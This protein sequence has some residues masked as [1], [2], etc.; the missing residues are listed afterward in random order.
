MSAAKDNITQQK[1]DQHPEPTVFL[2]SRIGANIHVPS[3]FFLFKFVRAVVSEKNLSMK[4]PRR[5]NE[6]MSNG[7]GK[8]GP[9]SE[10]VE[11]AHELG[12]A[13]TSEERWRRS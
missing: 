9:C 2:Q 12:T 6:L 10:V 4:L 5:P 1:N 11:E 13:F 3:S 7:N 8:G